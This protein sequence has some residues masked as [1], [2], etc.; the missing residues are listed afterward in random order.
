MSFFAFGPP[1][2][3]LTRFDTLSEK[4]GGATR[5]VP[6]KGADQAGHVNTENVDGTGHWAI[7]AY[8]PTGTKAAFTPYHLT[9]DGDE[10]TNPKVIPWTD[11]DNDNYR[12]LVVPQQAVAAGAWGWFALAGVCECFVEGTTDVAKDDYLMLDTNA[13]SGLTSLITSGGTVE[14]NSTVAIATEAQTDA[15]VTTAIRV[16]LLGTPK[17][18]DQQ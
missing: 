18:C 13:A 12:Y 10:E 15:S 1:D 7:F 3:T 2:H 16:I 6:N 4:R 17:I 8:N 11:A 9:L 14:T 5:W